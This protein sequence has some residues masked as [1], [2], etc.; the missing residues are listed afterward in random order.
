MMFTSTYLLIS[1][2]I[3]L[4]VLWDGSIIYTLLKLSITHIQPTSIVLKWNMNFHMCVKVT[5]QL[6]TKHL[7][8]VKSQIIPVA[9]EISQVITDSVIVSIHFCFIYSSCTFISV[10]VLITL[11]SNEYSIEPSVITTFSYVHVVDWIHTRIQFQQESYFQRV[12]EVH[13]G[14][15]CQQGS[16]FH[17]VD[18]ISVGI[19]FP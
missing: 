6:H 4:P 1:L 9:S 2:L 8:Y 3:P 10:V 15:Q 5:S 19:L 7:C 14:I 18:K 11:P 13:A 12:G 17:E 16:S